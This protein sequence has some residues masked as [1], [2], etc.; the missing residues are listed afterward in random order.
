M[1]T[2]RYDEAG[3]RTVSMRP[4]ESAAHYRFFTEPDILPLTV[5]DF[6]I[7]EQKIRLGTRPSELFKKYTALEIANDDA[8]TVID[9][10]ALADYFEKLIP[11]S[12]KPKSSASFLLGHVA[13]KCTE[14]GVFAC[15]IDPCRFASVVNMFESKKISSTTAKNLLS[16]LLEGDFD[17]EKTAEKEGL[18][19][20]SD[21]NVL[22]PLVKEAYESSTDAVKK[23]K[24]G[25]ANALQSIVG[26]VMGKTLG[27]A[28]PEVVTRILLL[29]IEK[30]PNG[31][32]S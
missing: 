5:D 7:E 14:N 1:E 23:Y 19:Q 24:N 31:D 11:W 26:K 6:D 4:K 10:P 3:K 28:D 27:K 32:I 13:K 18:F 8:F 21:E 16:R 30:H 22:Y 29:M 9:E 15:P 25:K 20:I 12:V 17:P 2:R